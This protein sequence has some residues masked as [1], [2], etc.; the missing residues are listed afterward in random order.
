M[1]GGGR[2][3]SEVLREQQE[4]F[5]LHGE[6]CCS[7]ADEGARASWGRAVRRA[8]PRWRWDGLAAGCFPCA[9]RCK[10]ESFRP[11]P[12]A[13]H[14]RCDEGVVGMESDGDD[15]ARRLSPVSVLDVLRCSDD[16]EWSSSPT[17]SDWEEEE[18]DDDRPSSTPG[19]S[20]PPDP[21]TDEKSEEEWRKVVS[22]W[23]RI[24]GDIARVPA[25][26]ELDLS[27]SMSMSARE[28]HGEAE[29]ERV[30]ASVEA[31][32]FEDMSAEAVRDMVEL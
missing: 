10:R 8:L 16:E 30:G 5:L 20:P 17:L 26:A 11:L 29:A 13:G 24:A 31:M 4:P 12:R 7:V 3:L 18:D 21:L 1:A 28:W 2:R 23:E 15:G 14:A 22:S 9:T 19:S 6:P 25:L 32:I 27:T